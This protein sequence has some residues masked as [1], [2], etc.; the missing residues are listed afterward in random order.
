MQN[1]ITTDQLKKLL[2]DTFELEHNVNEIDDHMAIVEE[3]LELT[4]VDV[5][6]IVVQVEKNFSIKLPADNIKKEAFFNIQSLTD[7]INETANTTTTT[8]IQ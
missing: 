5:L 4:S 1:E 6:E 7:Y 8:T 2:I 3:G